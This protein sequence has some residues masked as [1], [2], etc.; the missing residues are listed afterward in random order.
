MVTSQLAVAQELRPD[1][2]RWYV[3]FQ[4]GGLLFETQT[5]SRSTI[6]FGGAHVLV[7]AKRTGLVLSVEEGFGKGE[8]SAYADA[9]EPSGARAVTFDRLRKYTATVLAFPL[10]GTVEPYAGLGFGIL[11]TVNTEVQG[12]FTSPED[13]GMATLL[14]KDLG[15]TGIGTVLGGAQYRASP[16][17]VVFGHYQITTSPADGRLLRGPSHTVAF[18]I[19]L[20]LGRARDEV[21]KSGGS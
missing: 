16:N 15:S 4:T 18:G 10:S 7:M 12:F 21:R 14:V 5:Q 9:D 13:A 20:G 11:H 6:P 17:L 19:R 1:S 8:R 3:G 2:H